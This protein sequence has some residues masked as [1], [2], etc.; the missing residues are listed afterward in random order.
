MGTRGLVVCGNKFDLALG[1]VAT[2]LVW[3]LGVWQQIG[4]ALGCTVWQRIW[5]GTVAEYLS[6]QERGGAEFPNIKPIN[7]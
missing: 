3:R 2:D 6:Q 4:F 7:K 1:C 5:C